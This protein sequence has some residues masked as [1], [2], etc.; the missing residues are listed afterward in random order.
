MAPERVIATL[1]PTLEFVRREGI[2]EPA[3]SRF[4]VDYVE[5]LVEFGRPEEATDSMRGARQTRVGSRVRRLSP[6][7]CVVED[8]WPAEPG[9]ST[10]RSPRTPRRSSGI[11]MCG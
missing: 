3:A 5:A 9:T 6:P 8:R 10:M 1:D 11:R 4:V 2:V 7:V